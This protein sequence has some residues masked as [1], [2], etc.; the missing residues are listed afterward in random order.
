MRGKTGKCEPGHDVLSVLS[1]CQLQISIT[2]MLPQPVGV[3]WEGLGWRQGRGHSLLVYSKSTW[4]MH[5]V[6][7]IHR[8]PA[9]HSGHSR[10]GRADAPPPHR[11]A[12]GTNT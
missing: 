2:G 6:T 4:R 7:L 11:L 9:K 5:R 10:A 8:C 12:E 1:E 3:P